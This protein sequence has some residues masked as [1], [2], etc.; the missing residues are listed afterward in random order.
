MHYFAKPSK[1][2]NERTTKS[3]EIQGKYYRDFLTRLLSSNE[4]QDSEYLINFASVYGDRRFARKSYDNP[5]LVSKAS[6]ENLTDA[7]LVATSYRQWE[8]TLS[9]QDRWRH[10][11]IATLA[12]IYRLVHLGLVNP[13]I[14][15]SWK[16]WHDITDL[17][18]PVARFHENSKE[19]ETNAQIAGRGAHFLYADG[20]PVSKMVI[21]L[22]SSNVE[23]KLRN[24][25]SRRSAVFDTDFGILEEIRTLEEFSGPGAFNV[26][27]IE[28]E[29]LRGDRCVIVPQPIAPLVV[30]GGVSL[31]NSNDFA[32]P[33]K[34]LHL[35][36]LESR[37]NTYTR[38]TDEMKTVLEEQDFE[39]NL[40]KRISELSESTIPDRDNGRLISHTESLFLQNLLYRHHQ[41]LA[42][43]ANTLDQR[44]RVK[45]FNEV[46]LSRE[47][48]AAW[49]QG[50]HHDWRFFKSITAEPERNQVLHRLVR[51]WQQ[52]AGNEKIVYWLAHGNLL[53]WYWQGTNFEWDHDIDIQ[54]PI[55]QM[56][57]LSVNFN[58]SIIVFDDED[59]IGRYLL[60]IN[61]LY[62]DTNRGRGCN[63]IDA[64]LIDVD[65]GLY[66]DLTAV[67]WNV[68]KK[69]R[70]LCDKNYHS[71]P[72]LEY[73][74][75]L[76]KTEYEGLS[77]YVPFR[78]RTILT[79]EYPKGLSKTKYKNHIFDPRLSG[80]RLEANSAKDIPK[81]KLTLWQRHKK[82]MASKDPFNKA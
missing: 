44:H 71:Y 11:Y 75:P 27:R 6:A 48:H 17:E 60:E 37:G 49:E 10:S 79:D 61:P 16:D 40:Q 15:F 57:Y 23:V 9:V 63:V 73:L 29:L 20:V 43:T 31:D 77:T 47:N 28:N 76:Q 13:V 78:F 39:F 59:Y 65:T 64:R 38:E 53:S 42:E 82:E 58:N 12:F 46:Q 55:K 66:I 69:R 62:A 80:W 41:T 56:E 18:R 81:S 8:R 67:S 7:V 36:R 19:R 51:A 52:F 4:N 32:A 50:C 1:Y 25:G 5:V 33:A 74:S 34:L 2:G 21:V 26:S 22:D 72:S 54:L 3:L 45:F 68:I 14:P 30:T 35:P 24:V 70:L